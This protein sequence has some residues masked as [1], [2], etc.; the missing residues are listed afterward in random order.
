MKTKLVV[1]LLLLGLACAEESKGK[2]K[3]SKE[4]RHIYPTL[5]NNQYNDEGLLNSYIPSSVGGYNN[6]DQSGS[7]SSFSEEH[8]EYSV[9]TTSNLQSNTH[10]YH[11]ITKKVQVPV[12]QPYPVEVTKTVEVPQPYRVEVP[13]PY[14]VHY[15]V[16]VPYEVPKPYYVKVPKPV[17]YQVKEHVPVDVPKPYPV[18]VTKRVEV[19]VEKQIHVPVAVH[20]SE[21]VPQPYPVDVVTKEEVKVPT[22]VYVKERQYVHSYQSG[23]PC[24]HHQVPQ[25]HNHYEYGRGADLS[26]QYSHLTTSYQKP[27]VNVDSFNT[28]GKRYDQ[29][30]QYSHNYQ[31]YSNGFDGK[32]DDSNGLLASYIPSSLGGYNGLH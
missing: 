23:V 4:K 5:Y 12:P 27:L 26:N 25:Y 28:A 24:E 3:S 19:P 20:V 15:K 14:P 32:I 8:Q 18:V 22:P 21:P 31:S 1:V 2:V 6:F 30:A 7:H 17:P 10:E 29:G 16:N 11:H 9:P 13:K